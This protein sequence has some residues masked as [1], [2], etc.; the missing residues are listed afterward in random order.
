MLQASGVQIMALGA[1]GRPMPIVLFPTLMCEITV[2]KHGTIPLR[3][4]VFMARSMRDV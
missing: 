2:G 4:A 1:L 3:P